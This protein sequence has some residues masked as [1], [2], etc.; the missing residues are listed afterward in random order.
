MISSNLRCALMCSFNVD[1]L[2]FP[3]DVILQCSKGKR[4]KKLMKLNLIHLKIQSHKFS[5]FRHLSFWIRKY[6]RFSPLPCFFPRW[7][8]CPGEL[9]NLA[10]RKAVH[11]SMFMSIWLCLVFCLSDHC[12][13]GLTWWSDCNRTFCLVFSHFGWGSLLLTW[14]HISPLWGLVVT[15]LCSLTLG[16]LCGL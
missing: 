11:I 1:A 7:C 10:A 16:I 8:V 4:S 3:S 14:L 13:D 5:L 15:S 9:C 6:C 12:S 2:F